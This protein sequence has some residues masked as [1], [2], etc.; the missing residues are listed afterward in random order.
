MRGGVRRRPDQDLPGLCNGLQA[1]RSVHDVA[2][3][4][5]VAAGAQG[6]HQDFTRVHADPHLDAVRDARDVLGDRLLHAQGGA[7]GALAIVFVGDRR[8]EQGE[9]R[10]TDDL[11]DLS[12]ES[13][14]IRHEALEAVVDQVLQ[15]LGIH[16]L[17]KACEAHEVGEKHRD[18][19]TFIRARHQA[20][21]AN[22]AEPGAGRRECAA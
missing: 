3:R 7:H 2:H 6:A 16:G 1:V 12:A 4:G 17:G 11:V 22:G 10:V 21:P 13:S 9:D 15:L 18:H 20:V 14:D 5:V 19:P 8:A